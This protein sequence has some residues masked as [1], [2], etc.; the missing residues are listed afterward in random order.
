[1]TYDKW[2][3]Q[4]YGQNLGNSHA[5]TFTSSAQFI[6]SEVPLRPRVMGLKIG[7]QFLRALSAKMRSWRAATPAYAFDGP[8]GSDHRHLVPLASTEAEVRR[9]RKLHGQG[10]HAEA[11]RGARAL[12]GDFPENRDLLLIAAVEPAPL[13]R[14]EEALA[15]LE[16]LERL[17]AAVQPDASG[18][19]PLPCRAQGCAAR[20]SMRCCAR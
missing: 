6:K 20:R 18:A 12:L 14:I 4:M 2:Y 9:L 11:L 17:A 8:H 1:M 3:A 15:M 19:R 7:L 5:S 16:R 13:K 10:R